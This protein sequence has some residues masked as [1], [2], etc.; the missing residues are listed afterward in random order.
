MSQ[1][2][3]TYASLLLKCRRL[4]SSYLPARVLSRIP[5]GLTA[6]TKVRRFVGRH[7]MPARSEWV[8]VQGGLASGLWVR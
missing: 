3:V 1:A 2:A 5:G 7:L 8:Q 4:L 6:Y